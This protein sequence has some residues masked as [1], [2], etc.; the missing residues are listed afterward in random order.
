MDKIHLRYPDESDL[1][2]LKAIELNPENKIFS[3][4]DELLNEDVLLAYLHS[5]QNIKKFDQ[6]RWII[7]SEENKTGIIDLY[8][9]DF[10]NKT[11][12]IGII[13]QKEYRNNGHA[14]KALMLLEKMAIKNDISTLFAEVLIVNFA[15]LSLFRSL[16][17]LPV[18]SSGHESII[19]RKTLKY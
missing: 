9:A 1:E 7:V 15:G 4:N 6:I 10:I 19:L 14:K 3:K 2:F 13:I 12:F 11:A 17:Y 16:D 8:D 18:K 5:E